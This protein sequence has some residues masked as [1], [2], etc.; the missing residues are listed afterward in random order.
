MVANVDWHALQRKEIS[1]LGGLERQHGN[2][3]WPFAYDYT[4]VGLGY[5]KLR[6]NNRAEDVACFGWQF[7]AIEKRA[8]KAAPFH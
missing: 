2:W 5:F 6:S 8:P 3:T 1:R 7:M 4:L